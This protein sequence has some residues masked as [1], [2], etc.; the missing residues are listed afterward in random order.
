M[1]W[2]GAVKRQLVSQED[3]IWGLVLEEHRWGLPMR[4]KRDC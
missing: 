1:P 2:E 4:R 3:E